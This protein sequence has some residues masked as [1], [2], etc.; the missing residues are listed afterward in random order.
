MGWAVLSG[1]DP[2]LLNIDELTQDSAEKK[3]SQLIIEHWQEVLSHHKKGLSEVAKQWE[4]D[5]SKTMSG[6]TC[7]EVFN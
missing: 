7:R 2:E 5:I 1:S 6:L 3:P 4:A